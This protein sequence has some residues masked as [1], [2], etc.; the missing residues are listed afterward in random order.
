MDGIEI[1]IHG[2]STGGSNSNT[3]QDN[4]TISKNTIYN[5]GAG[6]SGNR[7]GSGIHIY[8]N[9][10]SAT[11]TINNVV[12]SENIIY[13]NKNCGIQIA[14]YSGIVRVARNKISGNDQDG[15]SVA[16]VLNPS[17][18]GLD[19]EYN[20]IYNNKNHGLKFMVPN[21]ERFK[22]YNNV[23]YNNGHDANSTFN[24]SIGSANG[25]NEMFNNI[26]YGTNSLC[27][28]DLN[29]IVNGPNFD[30]NIFCRAN[31]VIAFI[32]NTSAYDLTQFAN[33]KA[34]TSSHNS[35]YF[36]DPD[37]ISV[38]SFN[39]K[40]YGDSLGIN[41]GKDVGLSQDFEGHSISSPPDIG[42]YEH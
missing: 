14:G 21:G 29:G 13:D 1:S 42:A 32:L 31:G 12:I 24:I 6:W 8:N 5:T 16:D 15:V 17:S 34:D 35:G 4:I 25:I 27:L 22:L 38:S 30:N 2:P 28:Y 11:S 40:L 18:M 39:F 37:F 23:F 3:H 41:S 10:G 7:N 20:L 36:A 9:D 33:F 26:C 19:L